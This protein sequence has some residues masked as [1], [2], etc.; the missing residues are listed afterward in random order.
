LSVR[1]K[2]VTTRS[3]VT[4]ANTKASKE[5][6]RAAE[7]A[8][9]DE[10]Q[11]S[12]SDRRA[13]SRFQGIGLALYLMIGKPYNRNNGSACNDDVG[14]GL[15]SGQDAPAISAAGGAERASRSPSPARPASPASVRGPC[16]GRAAITCERRANRSG[17]LP[18]CRFSER[19]VHSAS[20][21][22]R[23]RDSVLHLRPR[24]APSSIWSTTTNRR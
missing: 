3:L 13:A 16:S 10:Q 4:A 17:T 2:P 19:A 15:R 24:A 8:P 5:D 14:D 18:A 7:G 23:Q 11:Q 12:A 9:R 21:K 22:R 6:L 1:K 20:Y